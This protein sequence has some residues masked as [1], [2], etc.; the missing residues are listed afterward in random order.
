[1]DTKT[2]DTRWW[3]SLWA[4]LM[5]FTRL[6]LWRIYQ[7]PMQAYRAVVEYWPI[8]GWLTG[9]VMAAVI[10]LGSMMLPMAVAVVLAII[11]RIL[12]TGAL[13]EDGLADFFDGFG[14]GGGDRQRVLDIMKDSRIGTFGVLAIVFQSL[15]LWACLSSLTPSIAALTV[16][17]ADPYCKMVTAQ[18]SQLMPYARTEATAKSHVVYR[19]MSVRAGLLLFMQGMLPLILL[20]WLHGDVIRWEYI[21]FTPCIVFYFLYLY[22]W[23]RLR[24]YTGDCCGAVFL[25]TETS[26]YLVVTYCVYSH[27][28]ALSI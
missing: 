2:D 8:A 7:P 19:R 21:V 14:G 15:I 20:L 11:A 27:N 10:Y 9:G 24:G 26:F 23:N 6:P 16:F 18:L 17:A 28:L 22:I 13:H 25:L 5:F 12:L 4:A 1:M 3:Q